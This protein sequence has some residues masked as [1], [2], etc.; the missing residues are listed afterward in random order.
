MDKT[1]DIN[2][3]YAELRRCGDKLRKQLTMANGAGSAEREYALAYQ[4]L[5]RLGA[6]PQLK[7]KYR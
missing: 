6:E 3:A 7:R 4:T 2:A 5:V 1:E